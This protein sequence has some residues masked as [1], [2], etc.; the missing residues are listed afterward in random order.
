MSRTDE[1]HRVRKGLIDKAI[2]DEVQPRFPRGG[3]NCTLQ[4]DGGKRALLVRSDNSFTPEGEY[5]SSRTGKPLAQ[6]IDYSQRPTTDGASQFIDVKGKRTRI[7]T[8]DAAK[9]EWNYTRTGVLWT[10]NCQI[11]VIVEIPTLIS[12]RNASS[13]REWERV[14]WMPYEMSNLQIEKILVKE[15]LTP[16]QR[17]A[18]V[19]RIILA[20]A[21][22]S[23]GVV[24]A[25]SGEVHKVDESREF[26]A[27]LME[28]HVGPRGPVSSAIIQKP[29]ATVI[30]RAAGAHPQKLEWLPYPGGLCKEA[31]NDIDDKCCVVRQMVETLDGY[32]LAEIQDQMDDI[33]NKIYDKKKQVPLR[34]IGEKWVSHQGWCWRGVDRG[35]SRAPSY[36]DPG[37]VNNFRL[38]AA[39]LVGGRGAHTFGRVTQLWKLLS[40]ASTR[41][42]RPR[43]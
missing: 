34:N 31:F 1:R 17:A 19:K 14:G 36:T 24:F 40:A 5:W 43:S 38:R 25:A 27:S 15:S 4:L 23:H 32:E 28:T 22:D 35:R 7:K 2:A 21:A 18:E 41:R 11:E 16:R 20:K 13:G 8:W 37:P 10:S 33:Q 39:S 3:A 29:L 6:G 30:D 42:R 12:G 9:N 26:R